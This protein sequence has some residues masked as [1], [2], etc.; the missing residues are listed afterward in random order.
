[1][2]DAIE[3]LQLLGMPVTWAI[4][5]VGATWMSRKITQYENRL[6]NLEHSNMDLLFKFDAVVNDGVIKRLNYHETELEVL[7]ALCEQRHG[8]HHAKP[9]TE[10][11]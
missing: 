11:T 8:A 4:L 9:A 6:N 10:K 7:K 3:L 2:K 5:L 1:M